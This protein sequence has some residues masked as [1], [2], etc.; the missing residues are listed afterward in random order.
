MNQVDN[1]T[2]IFGHIKAP[3]DSID[4]D[5]IYLLF[6]DYGNDGVPKHECWRCIKDKTTMKPIPHELI[7]KVTDTLGPGFETKNNDRY[8][9]S[10]ASVYESAYV[11]GHGRHRYALRHNAPSLLKELDTDLFDSLSSDLDCIF[12]AI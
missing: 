12:K 5:V 1:E 7:V 8:I 3:T 10:V 4:N 2:L 6:V 11:S 9:V